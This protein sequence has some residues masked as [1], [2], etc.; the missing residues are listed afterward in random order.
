VAVAEL[1]NAHSLVEIGAP[2]VTAEEVAA[3][4]RQ[5]GRDPANHDVVL[6]APGG[7]I[8]GFAEVESNRPWTRVGIDGY[9][10][11][12]V[13]GRGLGSLLLSLAERRGREFVSLADP[14]TRVAIKHGLREGSPG[15]RLLEGAGYRPTR[16]FLRMHIDMEDPPKPPTWPPGIE[17]L[18]V[19]TDEDRRRAFEA[20]EE[21]FVDHWGYEPETFE[22]WLHQQT[23]PGRYDPDLWFLAVDGDQVAGGVICKARTVQDPAC[24]WIEDLAVRRPWR[25]RGVGQ[26][27]LRHAFAEIHARGIRKAALDV[28]SE[29]P[30]GATHLY[31][32]AGMRP[33]RRV[34]V[35]EKEL[36]ACT[37]A[38]PGG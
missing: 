23:V 31:E 3:W 10:H 33:V 26:A 12:D 36:R 17:P 11:P 5:P 14:G 9:V 24:A 2:D 29:N 18:R 35:F 37:D 19:Q 6:E 1:I 7:R 28:D 8:V 22:S 30:T 13:W 25:G 38:I 4:W 20:L 15:I 21:A 27:L 32:R 34:V 16:S